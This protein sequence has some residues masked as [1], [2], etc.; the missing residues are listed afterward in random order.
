M[1]PAE[2]LVSVYK[3]A[4][5]QIIINIEE[6]SA[7]GLS[8]ASLRAI[9][10]DTREVLA[11]LGVA[12]TQWI[13]EELPKAYQVGADRAVADLTGAGITVKTETAF[14][15]LHTEAIEVL[16]SNLH[17]SLE[18]CRQIIGRRVADSYR[19][20]ALESIQSGLTGVKRHKEIAKEFIN[21][22]RE[23]GITGFTDAA[24]KEWNMTTYADMVS[25]TGIAEANNTGTFNRLIE[26]G[27]DLVEISEHGTDCNICR[28]YE[29]NVYSVS[30]TDPKYPQLPEYPPF[31]CRC[32]H[33]MSA[34]VTLVGEE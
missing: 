13:E 11:D 9:L 12:T 8:T 14:G 6:K 2:R 22:L 10:A 21:R 23:K 34:Y 19:R 18:S 24:G 25:Q 15:K 27:Y 33:V 7:K 29:G 17:E 20:A 31:H 3:E 28:E 4:E 1:T 26:N 30:G 16:A 32:V 5:R